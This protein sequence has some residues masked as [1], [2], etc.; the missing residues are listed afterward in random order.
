MGSLVNLRSYRNN[1]QKTWIEAN[2][3]NLNS[4][5]SE[6]LT[7]RMGMT[8]SQVIESYQTLMHYQNQ[9]S[10]DYVSFRD[11]LQEQMEASFC[12]ELYLKLKKEHWFECKLISK[13]EVVEHCL[14]IYITSFT[15]TNR[16][17]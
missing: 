4:F 13:E 17:L 16:A 2:Q 7:Q 1:K 15:T 14:S 6:F 12:D 8:F 5:L 10:W 11:L 3:R 9:S